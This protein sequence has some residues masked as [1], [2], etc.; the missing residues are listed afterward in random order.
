MINLEQEFDAIH[1]VYDDSLRALFLRVAKE[2]LT[3][4]FFPII[5]AVWPR[6]E[7]VGEQFHCFMERCS[8][9][10]DE[11]LDRTDRE[12]YQAFEA[13]AKDILTPVGFN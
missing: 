13:Y 7:D 3:E 12:I 2:E 4:Q 1:K 5:R 6:D 9:H 8:Q 10:D 11:L